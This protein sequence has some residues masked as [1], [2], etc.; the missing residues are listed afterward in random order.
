MNTNTANYA[1]VLSVA[2]HNSLVSIPETYQS[3]TVSQGPE[4][5]DSRMYQP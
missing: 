1:F 4:I 3:G 2:P 5:F